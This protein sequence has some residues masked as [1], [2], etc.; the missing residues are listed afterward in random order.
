MSH[1]PVIV[2]TAKVSEESK[3]MGLKPGA[4]D[5]LT[6]LFN[7]NELVLKVRNAITSRARVR[8]KMRLEML[9]EVSTME[10][11]SADERF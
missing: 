5:C 9:R 10:V 7:K 4:D 2:L 3:F 1:I 11:I 6:E 8:E